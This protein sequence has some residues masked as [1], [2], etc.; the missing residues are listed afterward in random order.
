M[1]VENSQRPAASSLAAGRCK[2]FDFHALALQ[3]C[4]QSTHKLAVAGTVRS[5]SLP[6]PVQGRVA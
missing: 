4:C 3:L 1:E 6:S 5:V 2:C